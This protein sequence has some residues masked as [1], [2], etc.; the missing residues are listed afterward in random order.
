[1]LSGCYTEVACP[2]I[3]LA[4]V[5]KGDLLSQVAVSTGSTVHAQINWC[6][7]VNCHDCTGSKHEDIPDSP[8]DI[9]PHYETIK[10]R[11][12]Y[13]KA[14]PA[15]LSIFSW[16]HGNITEEQASFLLM[17]EARNKFLVRNWDNTL[18]LSKKLHGWVSHD[19]ILR[20]PEGYRLQGRSLSFQ[21]VHKL[22]AHYKLHPIDKTYKLGRGIDRQFSGAYKHI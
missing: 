8:T 15:D 6:P 16:Y 4:L 9:V 12:I 13:S 11:N 1:M 2:R 5:Y 10:E 18:I 21:S 19:V 3:P 7:A 20:S 22:V 17:R 14:E